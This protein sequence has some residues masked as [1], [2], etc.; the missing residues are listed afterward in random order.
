MS[1]FPPTAH[2][3]F[4]DVPSMSWLDTQALYD[5]APDHRAAFCPS[6]LPPTAFAGPHHETYPQ[7]RC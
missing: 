6:A 5:L 4:Q 3:G 2:L 1:G 7:W